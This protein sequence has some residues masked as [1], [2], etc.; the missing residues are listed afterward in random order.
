MIDCRVLKI[1]H[2][3]TLLH[4]WL[5]CCTTET[6]ILVAKQ[7][8][9]R[10]PHLVGQMIEEW[11]RRYQSLAEMVQTAATVGSLAT[12]KHHLTPHRALSSDS[13]SDDE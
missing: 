5:D 10:P 11:L 6:G 12:A 13:E 1:G 2:E 3:L 4:E 8:L 7:Q 9:I